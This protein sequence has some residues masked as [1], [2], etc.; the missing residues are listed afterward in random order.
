VAARLRESPF[1]MIS[2][3]EAVKIIR[4]S[5]EGNK[6]ETVNVKDAYGRILSEDVYS[7]CDLPPFRASIKDGYAVLASDGKG[8]RKVLGGV[9][10][11]T[12]VSRNNIFVMHIARE[13][14][15]RKLFQPALQPS[16][17]PGTC[18]RVNTGAPV[19]DGKQL[20][21]QFTLIYLR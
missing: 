6:V 1:P 7:N 11:G 12:A 18:V 9:K 4:T 16:L 15:K 2:V 17:K 5:V 21:L 14:N 13:N 8:K 19:P 20:K 3:E 10:A